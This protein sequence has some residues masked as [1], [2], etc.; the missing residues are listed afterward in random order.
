MKAILQWVLRTMMKDQTGIVR[1]MPKK[2][3]VDFNVAM[4][5]ERLLRNGIDPNSLK[6][7]NQVENAINQIEAPKNVQQG[8]KS[9]QTAKV[10]DMEGKEIKNPKNIMGGKEIPD[11]DLPPP[12]SRGGPEDIAAPVQSAEE[13][14]KNMIEAENKK[15]IAKIKNRK[16]I[17]EAIDNVSPGFVKGDRKYNA[18]L[19]AEDLAQKKFNKEFYDL[20]QKQQID[21][22]GEALDGLDDLDKFAQGGRAGFKAGLGKRF[23][24][25][26]KGKPKLKFDERRFREGPIDLKFLENIDKKDL[27]KFIKTRDT[28]GPGSYGMYDDF[29]DMP[30][31]LRAAELI[32]TIKTKDG[33]I[34]YKAAEL[35]LGK[36]LKGDE[37]VNELIQMLNRKEM[38]AQGGRAGFDN[39]GL[40]SMLDIKASGSKSGKQQI[41]G[42][43]E[44]ITADSESVNAIIKAD[45][46]ISQK[47]NLLADLQYGKGRTRI[48]KDDQEIFLD[49]GGFKNRNIGVEFNRG[50][51]GL[52][53]RIMYNLESGD[54]TLNITYKKKFNQGGIARLGFKDGMTR[55][56]F[57]KILGGAMS[58]PIIGKFLKPMKVGKTITKVPMIKTDDVAGKPEWFDALVN[59]VIIEGD[60]VTKRFATGERQTIHQKTLDDGSVVRVTE[61]VDQGAVRVEYDSDANVFEDTVQMEYKKP[62]PDEGDPRPRAEFTT[63][64]SGPVGRQVSPDDYDIDVDEISGTSIRDLD[65]DVSKLKEYATGK[66]LTMKEIVESKKRKDKALRITT[67]PEAQSDA[68]IARQGEALD[69]DDYASGGIARMLGE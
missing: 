33:A 10:F 30:A 12:G 68:V 11:D 47:I 1:T 13:T 3:L 37:S 67:D 60:D 34:N 51:E 55:R 31:G 53:S 36:K 64:E 39:G 56:T 19:V 44:G 4:T 29:A 6:N 45:I 69:Y 42:A 38:R 62:L 46:P 57:L 8:I 41:K 2:D 61:D 63:A 9:T 21:L 32:K 23:L 5:V 48:E 40:L 43:P 17:K 24:D 16:I 52:G 49:E 26:L 14:I 66:K 54:P 35:F 28:K 59:K 7:A 65:S 18:Q 25:L 58:I 15:N 50:G 22:Y 20:D 27:E